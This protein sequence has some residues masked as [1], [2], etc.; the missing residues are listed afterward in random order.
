MS[1]AGFPFYLMK[2]CLWTCNGNV[3]FVRRGCFSLTR[4]FELQFLSFGPLLMYDI[5]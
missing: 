5:G 4:K 2:V 1:D 3:L